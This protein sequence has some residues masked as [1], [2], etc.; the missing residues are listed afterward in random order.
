M[1]QRTEGIIL[2]IIKSFN[3]VNII[4]VPYFTVTPQNPATTVAKYVN[5]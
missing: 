2:M 4:K 5:F 1:C 3:N